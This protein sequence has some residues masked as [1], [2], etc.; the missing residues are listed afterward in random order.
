MG[1]IYVFIKY[2]Q[3]KQMKPDTGG[4]CSI[5]AWK[6]NVYRILDVKH[7]RNHY[8]SDLRTDGKKLFK[9]DTAEIGFENVQW[10]QLVQTRNLPNFNAFCHRAARLLIQSE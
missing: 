2:D 9:R 8:L 6:K 4:G 1:F 5:H 7:E 10:L 3:G